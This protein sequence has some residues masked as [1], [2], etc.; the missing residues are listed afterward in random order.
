MKRVL[1]TVF[2]V[3]A[4]MSG[5]AFDATAA[6]YTK[7]RYPIV[8]SHGF[9]GFDNLAGIVDYWT[10]IPA[11]LE[12]DGATVHMTT[13]SP[14]Q[15]SI[16][17]GEEI[18]AQLEELKAATG[19]EKFNLVGHSQGA[20]DARY[21]AT[22]RPD[23]VASITSLAGANQLSQF[24]VI[25]TLPPALQDLALGISGNFIHAFGGFIAKLSG[26]EGEINGA[27]AVD[28]FAHLDQFNA[29]FPIGMPATYCGEG[30]AVYNIDGYDIRVYSWAGIGIKTNPLDFTDWLVSAL[31]KASTEPGDGFVSQCGSHLGD[32]IRDDYNQNH[33]D[34]ANMMWGLVSLQEANPKTLFRIHANR[35]KQAGL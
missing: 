2:S 35:L 28:T 1:V 9:L 33:L 21:V 31:A 16:A 34:V 19:A 24:A 23:L 25:G 27:G 10:G 14:A 4:G 15:S 22:V 13:V 7:T 32:V 8:L 20:L 29:L 18:I 12:R 17:R 30:D 11:A 5:F 3:A 6:N 26:Y